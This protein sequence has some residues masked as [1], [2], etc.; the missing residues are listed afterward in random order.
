[1]KLLLLIL[2]RLLIFNVLMKLEIVDPVIQGTQ[3]CDVTFV[4]MTL[5]ILL[6]PIIRLK[7]D[8]LLSAENVA[9]ILHN[10]DTQQRLYGVFLLQLVLMDGNK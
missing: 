7:M 6:M 3:D 1:M 4:L 5:S 8:S 9:R 10:N 2:P